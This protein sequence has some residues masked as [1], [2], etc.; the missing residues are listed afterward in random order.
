MF[1]IISEN[2]TEAGISFKE[3]QADYLASVQQFME[4]KIPSEEIQE[5]ALKRV[6][7]ELLSDGVIVMDE[8]ERFAPEIRTLYTEGKKTFN[9]IK[10]EEGK[11]AILIAVEQA[12]CK[13][14]SEEIRAKIHDK[15]ALT[16]EE[17]ADILT[18][19]IAAKRISINSDGYLCSILHGN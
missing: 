4:F 7:L 14:K 10:T 19:L 18:R 8:K 11:N 6:L 9:R 15:I 13:F 16:P 2:Q 1:S 5:L 3:I 17:L 12:S